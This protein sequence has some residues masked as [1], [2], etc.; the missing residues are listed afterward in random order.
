MRLGD[1]AHNVAVINALQVA[2]EAK[3]LERSARAREIIER[4][5]TWEKFCRTIIKGLEPYLWAEEPDLV[6]EGGDEGS[7]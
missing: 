2:D 7:H 5:Y 3:L 6:R 1:Q 4:E